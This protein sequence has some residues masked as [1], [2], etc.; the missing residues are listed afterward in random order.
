MSSSESEQ[1]SHRAELK[2]LQF[3]RSQELKKAKSK[4]D[5]QAIELKYQVLEEALKGT[6]KKQEAV[7]SAPE[8]LIPE[9]LYKQ[10]DVSKAQQ[11]KEKKKDRLAQERASIVNTVGDGAAELAWSKAE[12]EAISRRLPSGFEIEQID[13]N[14]DCLFTSISIQLDA[15]SP[16]QLRNNIADFLESNSDDF[17]AF[18]DQEFGEYVNGIRTSS[19]G[20]HVELEATSRLLQR[21]IIVFTSDQ[22][23][24]FGPPHANPIRMSF[25]ERQYSSPHYNAVIG[26]PPSS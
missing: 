6:A 17:A 22:K 14:G 10:Q 15:K 4:Q 3:Q 12:L 7:I 9:S 20:S 2:K 25:H 5:K 1:T 8:V 23:L 18:V 11:K 13:P 24:E 16:S 26:S 21:R 19:W